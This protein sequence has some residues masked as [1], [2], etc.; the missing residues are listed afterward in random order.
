MTLEARA[1]LRYPGV[2]TRP[3]TILCAAFSLLAL[4]SGCST[5][6][7][8][9]TPQ[10]QKLSAADTLAE[11]GHPLGA[12]AL[13]V[14]ALV[15]EPGYEEARTLLLKTFASGQEEFRTQT[16]RWMASA[17]QA[18]WDRLYELYGWQNTLAVRGAALG[19]VIDPKTKISLEVNVAPAEAEQRDAGRQAS[20]WHLSLGKDL[21]AKGPGPRQARK[22]LAEGR[23]AAGFD[24]GTPELG[25]WL[26]TVTAEATQRLLVLPFFDEAGW[27]AG[28]LSGPLGSLISQHLLEDPGLPELTT[29][30]PS[31]RIVTLP[32]AGLA[33]VGLISQPD[34]LA[35]ARTAGQNL[36]LLG[37]V[38]RTVYQEPKKTVKVEARKKTLLV[39]DPDH[40]QGV[41]KDYRAEV[42][43]VTW[44]TAAAVSASFTVVEV[45]SGRDLITG[46]REAQASDKIVV[47]TYT[48]DP[49]A[50]NS[51]DQI[52][53]GRQDELEG[54]EALGH[55]ILGT[56]AAEVASAVRTA[57]R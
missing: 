30:Y 42:T 28:G 48:G 24:P 25:P 15:L 17:D 29:I 52:A 45:A 33:R 46:V 7:G 31:D 11:A 34:A 55:R 16:A 57:L 10:G 56:L 38:V 19:P 36:V 35:L 13:A 53:L 26:E 3:L 27:R 18:R 32:G 50:L 14:E 2:M 51:E 47:T 5:L 49:Q 6:K 9:F 12:S 4:L 40:P 8:W 37:Q 22:A 41:Y 21:L 39:V 44:T 23:A 1:A 43:A 20:L 54:P